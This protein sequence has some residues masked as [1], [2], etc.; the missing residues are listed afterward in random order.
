MPNRL[1]EETSPYLL[2]HADNP[3]DW[4]AWN[5]ESLSL[6]RSTGKPIDQG[7]KAD[8]TA[9]VLRPFRRQR[10]LNVSLQCLPS[11]ISGR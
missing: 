1:A 9:N 8:G 7:D 5:E 6:A 2:Q 4:H 10:A 3:V 11:G